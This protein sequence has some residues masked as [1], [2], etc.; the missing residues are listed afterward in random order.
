MTDI[1][2]D[3]SYIFMEECCLKNT[4]QKYVKHVKCKPFTEPETRMLCIYEFALSTTGYVAILQF[5]V[6][7]NIITSVC[8][9]ICSIHFIRMA[10][11]FVNIMFII[12]IIAN[13]I[14][15]IRAM[16]CKCDYRQHPELNEN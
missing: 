3:D 4:I 1:A 7:G 11:L 15:L 10:A 2:E 6:V 12:H 8:V 5:Q 14:E 16:L 9:D 13:F